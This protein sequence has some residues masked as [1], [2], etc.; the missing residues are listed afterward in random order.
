MKLKNI[1]FKKSAPNKVKFTM[2]GTYQK[3]PGMQRKRKMWPTMRIKINQSNP[4]QDNTNDKI[5]RQGYYKSYNYIL[6]IQDS[7]EP[8]QVETRKI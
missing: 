3:L 5:S 8:K 1:I 2:S 6:Y 4:T 7:R